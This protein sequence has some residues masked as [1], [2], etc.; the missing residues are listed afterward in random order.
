M[1][2]YREI[3]NQSDC[4][5]HQDHWVSIYQGRKNIQRWFCWYFTNDR[6]LFYFICWELMKLCK[7]KNKLKKKIACV[8]PSSFV[9]TWYGWVGRQEASIKAMVVSCLWTVHSV[10]ALISQRPM[11]YCAGKL[12]LATS[13]NCFVERS[14]VRDCNVRNKNSLN[15]PAYRSASAN[16]T[17]YISLY[18]LLELRALPHTLTDSSCRRIL[19]KD[20]KKFLFD[21]YFSY[22]SYH[23]WTYIF[24]I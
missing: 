2:N 3:A 7:R 1:L 17:F 23:K 19:K 24:L 14:L 5:R 11:I 9:R 15:I 21:A 22:T 10:R 4:F 13:Y 8:K 20:L 12:I 18:Q 16:R 6:F